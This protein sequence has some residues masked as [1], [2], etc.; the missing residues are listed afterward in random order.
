M[1]LTNIKDIL[2]SAK[3]IGITFHVS[4]D[5]DAAGS[6]LALYNGLKCLN[7][8]CYILSKEPLSDNLKF[9]MS[10]EEITG[11]MQAPS[12]DTDVVIVLDCGNLERANADLSNFT[13][14]LLNVDHHLSN[15]M[16]GQE[17]YVDTN[18]SATAEIVFELLNLMG[19]K[20]SEDDEISK[21][22]GTC[23]YTSLVTDTG[24][25]RHSNVTYKTLEI[26]SALR[27]IGVN[28]TYIYSSLFD[29][30]D[31]NR[32]KF[33][34]SV[35]SRMKLVLND[36]VALIELPMSLGEEF[37]MEIGDTSDIISY[38][39]QIKGVEVTLLVKEVEGGAKASLRAK[40]DVDVR[41]IAENFGG[42][43]HTKAAGVSMKGV[44]LT[45]ARDKL[46]E[47]IE[48]EL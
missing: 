14:T 10:S 43:G 36:K 35:I 32:I 20:F 7:K 37:G 9:L 30:K 8:D 41:K 23:I 42:G 15:D 3:K 38:G 19:Y 5:G 31:F 17:N 34:G 48:E 47:K 6:V 39:L 25:F 21:E 27:K 40:N 44:T 33:V 4:P 1:S 45:E 18:A 26:A 12:E 16:Y 2:L 29:N 24:C 13:G 22:I 28:N 11:D 46:L